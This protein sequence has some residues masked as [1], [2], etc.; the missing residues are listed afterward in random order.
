MLQ[1][2]M[3]KHG[4]PARVLT[5]RGP[6]FTSEAFRAMCAAHGT[7][8][9]RIRPAHPWTNRRIER[10]FRTFKETVSQCVWLF[11]NT[12][13][14]DRYCEDFRLWHNRDRPHASWGGRTPDE[15]YFRRGKQLRPLDRVDYFDGRLHSW[16]FGP[17]P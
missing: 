6:A 7:R 17:E 11:A 1:S 9:T 5:D 16:R 15:V 12:R 8:H 10:L 4:A 3:N 13:H 14:I 2:A